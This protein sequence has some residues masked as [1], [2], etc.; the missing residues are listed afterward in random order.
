[1]FKL[2]STLSA[3]TYEI[4]HFATSVALLMNNS[5]LPWVI[6]V[7]KRNGIRELYELT[8]KEQQQINAESLL[9]GKALMNEFKGDKLN[10]GTIGNLVPQLHLHHVIRY[11]HDPVWPQPVWGN[12]DTK[13]YTKT[14]S[15][16]MLT[17]LRKLFNNA[18]PA[19]EFSPC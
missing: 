12:L 7:P 3:D 2:H 1:M 5:R 19:I 13:P 4:G 15:T 17:R 16:Q 10:T 6:L 8:A 18:E 9:V 14:T 11:Y